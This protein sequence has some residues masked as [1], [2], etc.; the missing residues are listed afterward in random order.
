MAPGRA[1]GARACG[2]LPTHALPLWHDQRSAPDARP[3][4]A[5]WPCAGRGARASARTGRSAPTIAPG[6]TQGY[7]ALASVRPGR[8]EYVGG[9]EIRF[10]SPLRYPARPGRA[11]PAAGTYE[12]LTDRAV[13]DGSL[14]PSQSFLPQSGDSPW[15]VR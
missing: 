6:S 11:G 4:R 10:P 1:A 5:A 9:P 7:R 15:R 2:A 8:L 13:V 12:D 14:P 3:G